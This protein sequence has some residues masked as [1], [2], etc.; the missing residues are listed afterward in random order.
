MEHIT[1]TSCGIQ[2]KRSTLLNHR[3][4]NKRLSGN[5]EYYCQQKEKKEFV[6]IKGHLE[7]EEPENK[8]TMWYC[9]ACEKD[10]NFISKPSHLKATAQ[11]RKSKNF[12]TNND[13]T[14]K[15]YVFHDPDA[16]QLDLGTMM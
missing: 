8:K 13:R 12:G 14:D 6:Q 11:M 5:T 3:L 10:V 9:E 1:C 16:Y 4:T 2:K 15:T 7:S